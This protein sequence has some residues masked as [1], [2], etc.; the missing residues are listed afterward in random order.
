LDR[1]AGEPLK[2]DAAIRVQRSAVSGIGTTLSC[3][4]VSM[5]VSLW[6]CTITS[7]PILQLFAFNSSKEE[8]CQQVPSAS[9]A[10]PPRFIAL[11]VVFFDAMIVFLPRSLARRSK[12]IQQRLGLVDVLTTLSRPGLRAWLRGMRPSKSLRKAA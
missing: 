11:K 2:N 9:V 7:A 3:T 4:P 12:R 1:E 8:M 6:F 10:M 5:L